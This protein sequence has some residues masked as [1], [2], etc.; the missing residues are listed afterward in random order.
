MT[1]DSK[2]I[3][4]HRRHI[5]CADYSDARPIVS[6]EN[7]EFPKIGSLQSRVLRVLLSGQR[8]SHRGFD[9]HAHSY[10]LS[11]FIDKL[12]DKGWPIINHDETAMTRDIVPRKAAYT[13]YELYA[14]YSLELLERIKAFCMAVD[15]FETSAT[16]K[17]A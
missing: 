17:V 3:R 7:V 13:L 6:S 9:C 16:R 11:G 5:T 14:E 4:Q 8:L 12:R 1:I 15:D 2:V 10:R